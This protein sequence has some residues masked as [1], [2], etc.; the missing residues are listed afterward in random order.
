M[1]LNWLVAIDETE[2]ASFA[3]TYAVSKMKESDHLYLMNVHD[4]PTI[5]YA[6]YTTAE[7]LSSL[8]AAQEKKAK[9]ILVHFGH[10]AK[11]AGVKNFTLMKGASSNAGELLCKAVKQYNIHTVVV[12]RRTLSGVRRFFVGSTSQYVV[13]NAECTVV[14]AKM[15]CN[16]NEEHADK[17]KVIQLEEEERIRRV[18]ENIKIDAISKDPQALKAVLAAEEKERARRMEEDKRC[19]HIHLYSFHDELRQKVEKV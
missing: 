10:R 6:G 14:V 8:N 17:S 5:I 7:V 9:K 2:E 4:E 13:E 16:E 19:G 18:Q 15:Q 12:G 3:F 11:D 1:S